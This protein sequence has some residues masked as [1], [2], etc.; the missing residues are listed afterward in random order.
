MAPDIEEVALGSAMFDDPKALGAVAC[1]YRFH[2]SNDHTADVQRLLERVTTARQHMGLPPPARLKGMDAVLRR[3]LARVQQ[4][5]LTPMGALR[6]SLEEATSISRAD[7]KGIVVEAT[8]LEALQIP[9][10]ILARPG[11][12]LEIGVTHYK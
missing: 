3:E 7:T 10:E 9:R 2:R 5:A 4:G 6:V 8:S 1:G 12:Q 11:L